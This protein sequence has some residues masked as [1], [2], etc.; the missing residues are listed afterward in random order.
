M[1]T[2]SGHGFDE[3][4]RRAQAGDTAA[5]DE[6]VGLIYR[7]IRVLA[8]R[9]MRRERSGHTLQPTALAHETLVKILVDNTLANATSRTFLYQAAAKAMGQVLIDHE[10][11]RNAQKRLGR[12]RRN[13]L[14]AA[15]D[16]L[17]TIEDVSLTGLREALDDL[18]RLKERARLVVDFRFF[19]GMTDADVAEALGI[20]QKT[21]ERDWRFDRGWLFERLKPGGD[22]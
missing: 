22:P 14:D 13:P 6:L 8:A 17:A 16:H 15:L 2:S 10:R 5:R 21:V 4:L 19:L 18:A 12:L 3:L 9:R 11:K 20:S 7:D 1:A